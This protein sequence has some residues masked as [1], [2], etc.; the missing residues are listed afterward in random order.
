LLHHPVPSAQVIGT[1]I[2]A[3]FTD[4][5]TGII[6]RDPI[7]LGRGL[8]GFELMLAGARLARITRRGVVEDSNAV[9]FKLGSCVSST[10]KTFDMA[11][12]SDLYIRAITE[13]YGIN[14]R[15]SGQ[16]I[17]VVYDETMGRG[18][19]RLGRTLE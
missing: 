11:L 3:P 13:K 12:D 1:G 15:G 7:Q 14:L 9:R 4:I 16:V 6:C 2:V 19:G 8:T 10:E 5:Y 18:T 17:R